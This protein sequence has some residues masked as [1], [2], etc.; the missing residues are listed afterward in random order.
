MDSTEPGCPDTDTSRMVNDLD[1]LEARGLDAGYPQLAAEAP[2]PAK[3]LRLN[4]DFCRPAFE[5]LTQ[6][7]PPQPDLPEAGQ[8]ACTDDNSG[9]ELS[10]EI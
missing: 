5:L 7:L 3:R 2:P 4:R 1:T 6:W 8:D 9:Y 10:V